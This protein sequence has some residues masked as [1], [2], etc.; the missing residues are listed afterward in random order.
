MDATEETKG[1]RWNICVDGSKICFE[2]FRTV[3]DNLRQKNDFTIVSHVYCDKKTYLSHKFKP[4]NIKKNYESLMIGEHKSKWELIFE[5][6]DNEYTT[7][8]HIIKIAEEY[9][10]DILVLGYHGR[11]GPKEDPT[12]LGSNVDLIARNPSCPILIIKREENRKEKESQGYRFLVCCDGR[13][14]SIKALNT[15]I[16][17]MDKQADE[18]IV[19]TA[20]KVSS[21]TDQLNKDTSE[22]CEEAGVANHRF[23][24]LD[25]EHGEGY[26]EAILDYINVDDTPYIDFVAI[27]N[28]G[29]TQHSLGD[30]RYLGKVSKQ[31]L[32]QSKANVLLV[33]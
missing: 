33:P 17:L 21:K 32:F 12:L 1:L 4:S 25:Q 6:I 29:V 15:V 22:T 31:V 3:F 7:K 28:R 2:A 30:D 26:H 8:D 11:K 19:L 5:H 23:E 24:L 14:K 13:E 10:T 27:A 20:Y 18:L 16:G 9:R